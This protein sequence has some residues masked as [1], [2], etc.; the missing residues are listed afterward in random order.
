M[1]IKEITDYLDEL[2]P[3][4]NA[5]EYDNPGLM[6]GDASSFLTGCVL[7]LDCT[8]K[9][10]DAAA[11][12]GCNLLITHHP[13]IFGGINSVSA[14]T[15]T[16][17]LITRLIKSDIACFA[18]HTNL[19]LTD[20]FGDKA[21]GEA[22]GLGEGQ[23]LEGAVCG[24]VFEL[25]EE[26]TLGSFKKKVAEG[27][28]TSGIITINPDDKKVKKVFIQGGSFDEDSIEALVKAG[29]DTVVS[30]EIKHHVTVML[31]ELGISAL[32]AGHSATE[33][34]YLP[35]LKK[36]LELKYPQIKFIVNTN[37]E[38]ASVL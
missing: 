36:V 16:G 6:T 20:E 19:D 37:N 8:G 15:V 1:Q 33:Q 7:S 11:K 12:N 17:R 21:I 22:I 14:E 13:I 25:D 10:I 30:G 26:E 31:E 23:R 32:I 18:C 38:G 29:V 27:L 9:A 34:I 4:Q 2:F 24:S 35:K 5:L 28:K 3:R